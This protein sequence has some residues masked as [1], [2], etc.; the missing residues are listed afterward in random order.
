VNSAD[1]A[2]QLGTI[3]RGKPAD[4]DQEIVK[5]R[6]R[7]TA[8]RISLDGKLVLDFG[9]GN[10]AQTVQFAPLP[11]RL[12]AVDVHPHNLATLGNY[13]RLHELHNIYP[14]Q[15]DGERLPFPDH[16]FDAM[17]SFEVLEHVD[18]EARALAEIDRVLKPGGDLVLS[19]PNKGWIF[20]THGAHLPLLPW[21]RV[22]F[23]SWLPPAIR[24]R[25]A[26]ARIYRRRDIISILKEHAFDIMSA[27]YITAPMDIVRN[28]TLQRLLR[29]YLFKGDV[30]GCTL[31]STSI[32]VHSRKK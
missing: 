19:V 24:R 16:C 28:R 18:S 13:V 32:L 30:T 11:C 15:Y 21:N 20:E 17:I 31:L 5:R 10:G 6:L 3:A 22:P 12:A 1:I 23:F 2:S 26:R 25:F 9:C 7:L 4:Y 14:L 29:T 27:D 8:Q